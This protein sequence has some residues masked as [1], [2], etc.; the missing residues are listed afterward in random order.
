M[1][2]PVLAL[3]WASRSRTSVR[4]PAAAS[5]V[6]KLM[7][8][9]VLPT[10][11]FWLATAMMRARRT[12]TLARGSA[13]AVAMLTGYLLQAK[14]DP[15]RIGTAL[16]KP[17]RH[18]PVFA[19][20]GQFIL[21]PFPFE[22]QTLGLVTEKRL[23]ETEQPVKRRAGAGGHDIDR[24][25]RD[26]L[27]AARANRHIDLGDARGLAKEGG[28]SRIGLDELDAAG[29]EDRQNES[30]QACA[31]AEIDHAFGIGGEKGQELCRIEDVPA[32]QIDEGIAANE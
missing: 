16:A 15:P 29:A 17:R 26:R 31:A 28:F 12:A 5:A 3:P 20:E 9:V 4:R 27:D 14:N 6:A 2:S 21:D 13:S 1:P 7:A 8:V 32:P 11:P 24:V 30:R 25:R 18:C 22:K 19:S 23:G 10:P